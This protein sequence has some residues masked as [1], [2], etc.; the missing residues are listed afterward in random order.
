MSASPSAS[1]DVPQLLGAPRPEPA[2]S[3][4]VI[5]GAGPRATGPLEREA[6][7]G[8]ELR[9]AERRLYFHLVDPY[10]S[11]P[12]RI[13]RHDP[14]PL[15]RMNSMA[16]D[17]LYGAGEAGEE[18]I[19]D[20]KCGYRSG[21]LATV[22]PEGRI[23]APGG[24]PHPSRIALGHATNGHAV[25]AFARPGAN[26]PAL[27]QNDSVAR[28]LSAPRSGSGMPAPSDALLPGGTT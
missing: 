17:R 3:T 6:V 1:P 15:L 27:R 23:L 26:A 24:G 2:T 10:P 21:R 28:T 13:W 16:E 11:R 7:S 20:A 18:V 5:V 14:S 4:V 8:D 9:P 12:G 22:L 25:A 19:E